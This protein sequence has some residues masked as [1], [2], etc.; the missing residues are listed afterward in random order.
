MFGYDLGLDLGTS[1]VVIS[2]PSKGV[3]LNEPSYVAY[4][5]E[6][7]KIL[8]SG[9]RAYYLQGRE[10]K[11]VAVVQPVKN[12]VVGN[13]ALTQQMLRFFINRVIKKNV[14]RPRIVASVPALLTDV[15]RRTMVSA[16][17]SAGARSVCLIEEPLCA[18]FGSGVDPLNPNG[19]FVVD[20]G[21]GSTDMAVVSQG[22]MNQTETVKIAGNRF[23]E[24]I[25]K[26]LKEKYDILVGVRTAEEIKKAIGCVVPRDEEITMTARGRDAQSG[27]PKTV[28]ITSNDICHCLRPLIDEITDAAKTMFE[29]SS[30]QLVADIMASELLL[31]GG[32][33]ELYGL[34]KLFSEALSLNVRVV[35][36]GA[37][38]VAK[39]AQVA[40]GKMHILDNYGYQFKTKEDVRIK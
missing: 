27:M 32:S 5:I 20:I 36:Q 4:D 2:T 34:D 13:Y 14:F 24:E 29:R 22:S 10:P 11:G 37:L 18:A 6:T 38:C 31:T 1:T 30:P 21:G 23:D 17:I 15:E 35:P 7:E 26:F 16:I 28:E 19:V 33:A 8:Y 25:V 9:R 3:A 39:G 12:G 40:L